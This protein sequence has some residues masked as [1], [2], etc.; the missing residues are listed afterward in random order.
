MQL[1]TNREIRR[2]NENG[3]S[4]TQTT[5]GIRY[6]K[7]KKQG[8]NTRKVKKVSTLTQKTPR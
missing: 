3:Q 6:R 1:T 4:V 7:E 5:L 2:A 8:K